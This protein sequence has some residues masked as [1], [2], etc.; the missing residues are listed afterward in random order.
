LGQSLWLGQGAGDPDGFFDAPRSCEIAR[1]LAIGAP[2][3]AVRFGALTAAVEMLLQPRAK[4]PVPDLTP[5]VVQV[6]AC[7]DGVGE[8]LRLM[9][10]DARVRCFEP[11]RCLLEGSWASRGS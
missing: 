8:G 7:D 2:D 10:T 4:L 11:S 6:P 9:D 5:G 1:I 3:Q